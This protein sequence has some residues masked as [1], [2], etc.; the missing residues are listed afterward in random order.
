MPTNLKI[1][2]GSTDLDDHVTRFVGEANQG[3]WQMPVWCRMFQQTLDGPARGTKGEFPEKGQG[4]SYRGS[5]PP[6]T[7]YEG[8]Q[9]RTNNY[10]N[11]SRKGHYQPYVPPQAHNRRYDNQRQEVNHLSLDALTRR[12]KEILATELQLQLPPCPL[13]I[14]TPKKENLDRQLDAALESGKLS[15]LVK[16]VRQQGNTRG[17]QPGNNNGKGKAIYMV[18]AKALSDDVSD[19]PLIIEAKVEGYLVRRVFVDQGAAVQ[20]MFEHY[21]EKLPSTDKARFVTPPKWVA[22]GYGSESVTS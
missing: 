2:H 4:M 1:Y 12:P 11:F 15:H 21:F 7:A 14:G 8:G 10:N 9:Q 3:E 13:M 16:D 18:W 5:R 20:V 6:R 17:R 19:E 22:A